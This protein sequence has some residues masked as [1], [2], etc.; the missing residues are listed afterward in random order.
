MRV[1]FKLATRVIGRLAG[2]SG[3]FFFRFQMRGRQVYG[4]VPDRGHGRTKQK[5]CGTAA[6]QAFCDSTTMGK[7]QSKLTPEQLT[8][9]QNI[10]YCK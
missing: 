9:L 2:W 7:T 3:P 6:P 5:K 10:T 1:T 4:R 8:E